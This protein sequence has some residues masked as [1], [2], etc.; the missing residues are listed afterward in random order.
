MDIQIRLAELAI[1][2]GRREKRT[3]NKLVIAKETRLPRNTVAAYWDNKIKRY[4]K[5]T[6]LTLCDYLDCY[7]DELMVQ[8]AEPGDVDRLQRHRGE[9]EEHPQLMAV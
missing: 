5:A 9:E 6:I 8:V 3:I 4:D 7:L 1:Q 2:K